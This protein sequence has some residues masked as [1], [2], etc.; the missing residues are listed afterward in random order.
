MKCYWFKIRLSFFGTKC[1]G[2]RNKPWLSGD[3]PQKNK[4]TF[5]YKKPF[6]ISELAMKHKWAHGFVANGLLR[7]AALRDHSS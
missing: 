2:L 1:L 3:Q 7:H 6:R 5:H 4:F